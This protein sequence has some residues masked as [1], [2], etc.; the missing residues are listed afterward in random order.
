M[1]VIVRLGVANVAQE[2]HAKKEVS[3]SKLDALLFI[4]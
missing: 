2:M 4:N 1:A 3:V